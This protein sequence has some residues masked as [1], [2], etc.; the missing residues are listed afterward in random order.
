[1]M[2]MHRA[3]SERV[4]DAE[5]PCPLPVESRHAPPPQHISWFSKQGAPPALGVQSLTGVLLH[6]WPC[7]RA[8]SSPSLLSQTLLFLGMASP[9]LMFKGPP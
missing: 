1:M 8:I 7:G 3:K 4:P 6:H 9:N 2:G 5:L